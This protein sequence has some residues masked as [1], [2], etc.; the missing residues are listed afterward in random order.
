MGWN[1]LF[2][3]V[4]FEFLYASFDDVEFL[5]VFVEAD[6]E[7]FELWGGECML[8]KFIF[9]ELYFLLDALT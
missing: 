8:D 2:V 7:L 5:A 9:G 6:D 3:C 1:I 4:E